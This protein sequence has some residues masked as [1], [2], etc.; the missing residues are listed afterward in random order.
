MLKKQDHTK[1]SMNK[2]VLLV[3]VVNRS[4]ADSFVDRIQA[5]GANVQMILFG[6]GT[7]NKEML[8]MLGLADSNKAVIFSII[9][10]SNVQAAMEALTDMFNSVKDG[11]GIAYT[12]PFSSIIG[13]SMFNFLSD[14]RT[15]VG[16]A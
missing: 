16:R 6:R 14:N 7:A 11:R 2:L 9:T 8:N 5:F 1:I 10:E 12:I 3:T 13:R 4:K 15:Q